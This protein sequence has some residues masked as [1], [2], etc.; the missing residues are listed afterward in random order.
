MNSCLKPYSNYSYS[1]TQISSMY[2]LDRVKQLIKW[3]LHDSGNRS[4]TM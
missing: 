1:F 3:E 4:Y 2:C